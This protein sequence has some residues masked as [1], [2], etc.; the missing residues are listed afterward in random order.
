MINK[1]SPSF[2]TSM[3]LAQLESEDYPL[4]G[5]DRHDYGALCNSRRHLLPWISR[6]SY[7]LYEIIPIY[8][9]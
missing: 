5:A 8:P 3:F 1:V 2:D 9:A 7:N 6:K 4:S